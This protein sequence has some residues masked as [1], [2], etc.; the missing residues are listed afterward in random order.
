MKRPALESIM[1]PAH[2][3]ELL[4][5][6]VDGELSPAEQRLVEKLLR[7]SEEARVFHAHLSSDATRLRKLPVA[8]LSEDLAA[9]ILSIIADK[10][11]TPTPF[12]ILRREKARDTSKL[13][14]WVSMSAAAGILIAVSLGSYFYFATSQQTSG[15]AKEQPKRSVPLWTN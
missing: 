13:L 15:V 11:L 7:D 3:Q 12:P 4:T 2:L 1:L 9:H 6:T 5:A 10:A 14:I 8:T